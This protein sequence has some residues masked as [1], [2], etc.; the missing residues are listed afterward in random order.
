[1][2]LCRLITAQVLAPQVHHWAHA[3]WTCIRQAQPATRRQMSRP[4]EGPEDAEPT[5]RLDEFPGH[6]AHAAVGAPAPD[7][8]QHRQRR[9]PELQG[10]RYRFPGGAARRHGG[11]ARRTRETGCDRA[12]PSFRQPR[13]GAG[14]PSQVSRSRA[15]ERRREYRGTGRG[16]DEVRGE[17]HPLRVCPRPGAQ[18]LQAHGRAVQ[19]PE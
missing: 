9:H 3:E 1:R 5:D 19:E 6:R 2:G 11:R 7:R 12:R 17:R 18:P 15:A 10:C 8:Q 4:P 14:D 13:S 16:A